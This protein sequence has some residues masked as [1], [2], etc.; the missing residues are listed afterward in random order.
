MGG[1]VLSLVW[2]VVL[3]YGA[4]VMAW[5]TILMANLGMIACTMLAYEKVGGLC[6]KSTLAAVCRDSQS[7]LY[8]CMLKHAHRWVLVRSGAACAMRINWHL[9]NTRN[10]LFVKAV[11]QPHVNLHD[12]SSLVESMRCR[13]CCQRAERPAGK[14]GLCGRGD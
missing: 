8:S 9:P 5:L 14:P 1:I 6:C 4:G 13:V 11:G 10:A 2:M 3:R 7:S 12:W